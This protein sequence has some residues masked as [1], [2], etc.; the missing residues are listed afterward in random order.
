MACFPESAY[1]ALTALSA[2]ALAYSIEPLS[3][4]TLV[5]YEAAWS[6]G[7]M[8]DY[9]LRSLLSENRIRYETVESTEDGLRPRVIEREGPTAC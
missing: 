2:R 6:G 7:E 3:H 8:A 1:S 5:I 9:L 4:R